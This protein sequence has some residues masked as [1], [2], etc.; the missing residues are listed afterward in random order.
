MI[1]DAMVEVTCDEMSC[2]ENIYIELE[3]GTRNT[4]IADDSRIERKLK[5]YE[6]IVVNGRHFCSQSCQRLRE[7][8]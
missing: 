3:A 5:E 2:R 7:T 8:R 1:H 6:W 4:Y